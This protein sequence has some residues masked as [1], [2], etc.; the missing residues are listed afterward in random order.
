MKKLLIVD[1]E[2]EIRAFLR[3]YFEGRGYEIETAS[4]GTEAL[5]HFRIFKPDCTLLDVKMN[6]SE[7]GISVLQKVKALDKKAKVIMVTALEDQATIQKAL[8]NGADE[9]ITKP[10]SLEYLE[11]TVM[12][13]LSQVSG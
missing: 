7:D 10:L 9:Y 4:N 12:D 5:E 13:K 6:R 1:D 8:Q 3:E 11:N 2:E